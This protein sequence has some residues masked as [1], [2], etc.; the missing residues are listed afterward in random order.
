[1]EG[2]KHAR[3]AASHDA[4]PEQPNQWNARLT[5]QWLRLPSRL[6]RQR[7]CADD[8]DNGD[9]EDHDNDDDGNDDSNDD[10]NDDGDNDAGGDDDP[11]ELRLAVRER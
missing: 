2:P 1:M 8:D 5:I 4:L 6:R 11:D 9:D 3:A 7:S 10:G